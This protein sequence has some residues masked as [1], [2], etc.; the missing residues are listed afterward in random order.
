M[1][2][3]DAGLAQALNNLVEPATRGDPE[4]PLRWTCKSTRNLASLLTADG[5][6][7]SY[8]TVSTLL[9][10]QGYSLQGNRKTLE[11][12]NHPDRDAQFQHIAAAVS[13]QHAAGDPAISVDTKKKELVGNFK[14]AGRQWEPKGEPVKVDSHDFMGVLGRASP[15]GVYD[16]GDNAGYVSVGISADTGEFAVATVRRWWNAMAVGR[17]VSPSQLLITADCGGS[18]GN[19]LRLWKLGCRSL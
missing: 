18:N 3:T 4:S 19:R 17:Y 8:K 6:P 14:N 1:A 12:R 10:G 13:A 9:K 11:G 15:Y 2:E 7:V 16:I 5:H